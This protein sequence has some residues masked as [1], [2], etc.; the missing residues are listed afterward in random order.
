M[1]PNYLTFDFLKGYLLQLWHKPAREAWQ[2]HVAVSKR[3][4]GH[5]RL[6]RVIVQIVVDQ[7]I[8]CACCS[9]RPS[10]IVTCGSRAC[11]LSSVHTS[12]E[13]KL[14][15]T[16]EAGT[17]PN[18]SMPFVCEQTFRTNTAEQKNL[19][20]WIVPGTGP[21]AQCISGPSC[22]S[23]SSWPWHILQV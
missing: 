18:E 16:P 5:L 20:R 22:D 4:S 2:K 9:A 14:P 13:M 11:K 15:D 6:A 3:S 17:T 23:K 12:T 7:I 1:A 10:I 21:N 19:E 8:G